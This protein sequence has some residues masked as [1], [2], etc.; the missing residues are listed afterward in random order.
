MTSGYIYKITELSSLRIYIGFKGGPFDQHYLGSPSKTSDLYSRYREL[1]VLGGYKSKSEKLEIFL[2]HFTLDVL[3]ESD[4]CELPPDWADDKTLS[5]EGAYKVYRYPECLDPL[6]G[7]NR[8]IDRTNSFPFL[9]TCEECQGQIGSHKRE[10][11]RGKTCE[12]CDGRAGKHKDSCERKKK[13]AECGA[14]NQY[15]KSD[16]GDGNPCSLYDSSIFEHSRNRMKALSATEEGKAHFASMGRTNRGKPKPESFKRFRSEAF[17]QAN[18]MRNLEAR[19]RMRASKLKPRI[20]IVCPTCDG[21]FLITE[22]EKLKGRTYC[23]RV[24]WR[25]RPK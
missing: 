18:P 17:T 13:C 22:K 14:S 1:G 19:E 3:E 24:C 25:N 23:S 6:T 21:G 10:C 2:R 16:R 15:H 9:A 7:F 12:L 8:N 20:S 11:S 5:L 4:S